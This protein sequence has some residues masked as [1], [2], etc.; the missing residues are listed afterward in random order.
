MLKMFFLC[1]LLGVYKVEI[2][3]KVQNQYV[4]TVSGLGMHVEVED[5]DE[6]IVMSRVSSM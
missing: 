3:D 1:L 4:P 6:E 2:F 5:P